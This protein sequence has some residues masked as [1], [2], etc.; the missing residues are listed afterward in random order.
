M[1]HYCHELEYTQC[2]F[3]LQLVSEMLAY[4][5]GVSSMPESRKVI[6]VDAYEHPNK[7]NRRHPQPACHISPALSI[8]LSA[9]SYE[10]AVMNIRPDQ[11]WS[12]LDLPVGFY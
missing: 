10:L 9:P 8:Y 5:A 12:S 6:R 4:T 1:H 3:Q 2:A 11:G 7:I